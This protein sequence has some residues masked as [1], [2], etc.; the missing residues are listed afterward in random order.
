MKITKREF[1]KLSS[2]AACA[3]ALSAEA[4]EPP[5]RWYKGNLHS[6]TYWSDGSAF[7]EQAIA[8][9]RSRGYNFYGMSDHNVFQ[10][11]PQRWRAV[12]VGKRAVK[13]AIFDAYV[14]DFPDAETRAAKDGS[15]EVRLKTYAELRRK[16][17]V[18]GE[19]LLLPA[20]EVTHNTRLASGVVHQ[21][22]MNTVNIPDVPPSRRAKNFSPRFNNKPVAELIGEKAR[23]AKEQAA[24][25]GVP[26]LFVLN[27]PV[28]R[29]YDVVPEELIAN[30]DVRFF[31]VCNN[32]SPFGPGEGLPT[33][34]LDTDRFWDIVNA[35]RAARGQKLLYGIGT[36][37]THSYFGEKAAMCMPGNAWTKVRAA[38][39]DAAS[40]IAAMEAGDF[41]TCE[42]LEPDDVAFDPAT[43]R[44][45]VSAVG[46]AGV[47]L[48]VDF[49]VSK[50]GFSE[51]PTQTF[52]VTPKESKP[53]ARTE[54][55]RKI[56]F[57]GDKV[58]C[59][60]KTV[61]GKPGES[62]KASYTLAADDL[63][64]RARIS[65]PGEPRCTAALHPQRLNVAWTQPLVKV[66]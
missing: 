53:E 3:G 5:K 20:V 4:A 37:D 62:V 34:G 32:G 31:E 48:T 33:D 2:A 42:G 36:D 60:V 8:W 14:R 25:L 23:E 38:R 39:L 63:Y 64:V 17:D 66:W 52:T 40:L 61:K 24:R 58:G 65:C 59:T 50:R 47:P 35:F 54:F 7:P 45:E 21:V 29:W 46:R 1:L 16:F 6:H 22:H 13:K 27:H 41:V 44:L 12:A 10:D 55:T 30:L 56:S 28:W 49:I 43:G 11:D 18:P 57:Y 9:Y 15:T 19:F 51:T 26:H